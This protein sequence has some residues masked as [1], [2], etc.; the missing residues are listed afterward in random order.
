MLT[1]KQEVLFSKKECDLILKKYA[2]KPIDGNQIHESSVS[3]TYKNMNDVEDRWILDRFI[4]WISKELDITI[5]WENTETNEFYLQTYVKGDKF[6]K[7]SDSIHNRLYGLGLL[8]NDD[9]EGGEFVIENIFNNTETF[10]FQKITGNCYFFESI[11]EHE[12]HEIKEGIRNIVLV[13]FKKSQI[14]YNKLKII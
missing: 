14:K 3:Y 10:N 1:L 12:L 7:H 8:L 2:T 5:D 11:Y 9:F 6:N 4:L 13:F